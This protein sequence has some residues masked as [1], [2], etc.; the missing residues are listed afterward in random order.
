[1]PGQD[2]VGELKDALV[3][4]VETEELLSLVEKAVD[5]NIDPLEIIRTLTQGM[6]LIGESFASGELFLPE[7]ILA[8][9][10]VDQAM[11]KLNPLILKGGKRRNIL[12]RLLIGTAAGD[13]HSI[14]KSIVST[15]FQAHG[16]EV[17][18]LGIDV[19]S[20]VFVEKVKEL[21]PDIVGVS[22][23]LT[24][25]MLKQKEVIDELKEAGL[26]DQVKVMV[27]GSVVTEEWAKGIGAYGFGSD[28][29]DA[30]E[31][32]KKLLNQ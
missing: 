23:L 10:S 21:K 19:P 14:G 8:G 13:V 17:S 2:V 20:Q 18:D 15:I 11:K 5:A 1:M 25:T 28:A 27:G 30:V 6:Q 31:K 22:A 7:L 4:A 12:G 9:E 32:A 16:F 3:Q 29:I 24:T 26:R